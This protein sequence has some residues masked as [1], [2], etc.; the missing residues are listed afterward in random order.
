MLGCS[1]A[2]GSDL[3]Q[4]LLL[5]RYQEMIDKSPFAVATPVAA[6]EEKSA[7]FVENLYVNGITQ[8][9]AGYFVSIRSKDQQQGF[10]LFTGGKGPDGITLV[11]V[12]WD[13]VVEK[14]RV[15]L[16]RGSEQGDILFDQAAVHAPPVA[17][18]GKPNVPRPGVF[19]PNGI[20]Q[21]NVPGMPGRPMMHP[22]P[23]N[24]IQP[25]AAGKMPPAAGMPGG[26]PVLRRRSVPI[27]AGPAQ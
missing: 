1:L 17:A 7:P 8:M 22:L 19:P 2:C 27:P 16:A 3:P 11:S 15:R 5:S 10:S 24:R 26:G 9:G 25:G 21:P 4:P 6:P 23:P 20:L 14:S 18:G 12:A 13:P